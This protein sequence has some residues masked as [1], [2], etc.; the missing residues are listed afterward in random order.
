MKNGIFTPR[1]LLNATLATPIRTIISSKNP[2]YKIPV[3]SK[4]HGNAVT[5][6]IL[7][8]L[9]FNSIVAI[10]RQVTKVP[11]SNF[12]DKSIDCDDGSIYCSYND[13]LCSERNE[14]HQCTGD[15]KQKN[16]YEY[17]VEETMN[18][19]SKMSNCNHSGEG[20]RFPISKAKVAELIGSPDLS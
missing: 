2:K 9:F 8:L 6:F 4:R 15:E 18:E 14:Y 19:I 13:V 5:W 12:W 7:G 11:E 20:L 17:I 16:F 10:L 1:R 3:A